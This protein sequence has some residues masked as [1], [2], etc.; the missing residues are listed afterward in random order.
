M[1]RYALILNL[2]LKGGRRGRIRIKRNS[3]AV[4]RCNNRTQKKKLI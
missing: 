3:T 2:G 4:A 1:E